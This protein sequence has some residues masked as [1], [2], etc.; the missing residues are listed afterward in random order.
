M[1]LTFL[2]HYK[3]WRLTGL[4][5]FCAILFTV[6]FI[7]REM[8]AFDYKD[9][10]KY[11]VSTC[12]IYSAPYATTISSSPHPKVLQDSERPLTNTRPLC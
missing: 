12:L 8:G 5:V 6:G 3:S 10:I 9:L 11:I 7:I 2:S 4:Y 1:E